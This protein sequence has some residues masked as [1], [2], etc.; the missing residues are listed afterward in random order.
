MEDSATAPEGR[1]LIKTFKIVLPRKQTVVAEVCEEIY[2][3]NDKKKMEKKNVHRRKNLTQKIKGERWERE[4]AFQ[5]K[6]SI[7]SKLA[8]LQTFFHILNH[9]T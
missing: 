5:L 9:Q 2:S 7:T 6:M 4:E 8:E 3:K 1:K